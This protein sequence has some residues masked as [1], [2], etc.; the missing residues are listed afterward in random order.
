MSGDVNNPAGVVHIVPPKTL[1]DEVNKGL[2]VVRRLA[3]TVQPRFRRLPRCP[4]SKPTGVDAKVR[5][6]PVWRG[7]PPIPV[8]AGCLGRAGSRSRRP[9]KACGAL[10]LR[11]R[12][13]PGWIPS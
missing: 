5:G 13:Q 10:T 12:D 11:G 2:M 4:V 7:R 1:P 6:P 8:Q 9:A 3:R